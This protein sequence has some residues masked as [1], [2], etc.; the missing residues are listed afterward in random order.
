MSLLFLLLAAITVGGA[1]AAILLRNTV[2]CALALTAVFAGLACLFLHL[3]AEFAG[4]VEV[5]VYIGAVAI[6]VVFAILLTRNFDNP[7]DAIYSRGWWVGI[8][9]AGAVFGLLAWAII[10]SSWMLAGTS[11]APSIPVKMIG[12]AL[13]GRFVL[14]LEIMAVLLTVAMIGAVIVAL[15]E[16]DK[17]EGSR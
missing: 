1:I 6:L 16:K 13:V 8:A 17:K 10:G 11:H 5:L 14:P 4:L 3:D 2:H 7:A 9:I 12:E 15:F